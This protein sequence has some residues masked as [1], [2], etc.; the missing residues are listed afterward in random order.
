[1]QQILATN[2]KGHE[3]RKSWIVWKFLIC[4]RVNDFFITKVIWNLCSAVDMSM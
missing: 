1:M 2:E 3:K 4:Q